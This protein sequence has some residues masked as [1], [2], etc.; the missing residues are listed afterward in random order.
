MKR[1]L[2]YVLLPLVLSGCSWFG[3]DDEP[4]EIKPNPLPSINKEVDLDVVWS[5]KIGNGADDRAIRLRPVIVGGRVFAAAADGQVKAMTTDTGRVIW[6]TQIRKLYSQAE[7]AQAF[8][9]D[10]DTI[11]GG[12]GADDDLVLVGT[13]SGEVLALHQSDGSLA[14]K[15]RVSSE[16][17]AAP[18]I[19]DDT[20]IVQT[21]DGKVAAYDAVDGNRRWIYETSAP[22]L[23]LRGTATPIVVDEVVV[24][25]FAT[26][27]VAF[28]DRNSGLA[29][30]DQ[31]VA[32]S[33]GTS[34]LERLVDIDGAMQVDDGKL[35]LA[36]FQ[37]RVV[38][39]DL[40]S[41]RMLW[42]EEASSIAG[43]GSGFGN[44]YLVRAD[45]QI[46]AYNANNGREIWNVDALLHREL[47]AP[48]AVGSYLAIT[49]LDGYVHLLAQS[50][51][52][53]VGRRK[54][55]T[56]KAGLVSSGGRLFAMGDGG[57]LTVLEIN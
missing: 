5:R 54:V 57:S 42:A 25:A 53:F 29:G 49:D 24:A 41:G 35:Y 22:S 20:V 55:D 23:T 10:I 15:T 44:A 13:A 30:Y 18:Q 50:D 9:E 19:A 26:G 46:T 1:V 40:Q 16:V 3:D 48:T 56:V 45:G 37:G 52:R 21:I 51:G 17:L 36:S 12:V 2:V 14:W 28:L 4:E 6:E 31:R 47:T 43:V 32:I 7:L 39:I 34:D 27:R 33:Q 11:T 38:A 8:P